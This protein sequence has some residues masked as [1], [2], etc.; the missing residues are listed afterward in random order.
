MLI[1]RNIWFKV[2]IL[3]LAEEKETNGGNEG[4]EGETKGSTKEK[5]KV[6]GTTL[7]QHWG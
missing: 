6:Q 2:Q 5:R 3:N 4:N 1:Q 7:N